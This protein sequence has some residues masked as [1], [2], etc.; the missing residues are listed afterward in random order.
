[1][2]RPVIIVGL[3]FGTTYS[4]IAWALQSS[5]EEDIEV[6]SSWPGG[7]NREPS[8]TR[9]LPTRMTQAGTS[10]K[11]PSVISYE[12]EKIQWGYQI[13][14][15][16]PA[17]RGLKLLLDEGQEPQYLP[18][19]DTVS[20]LFQTYGKTVQEATADYLR[21]LIH[22][23][24]QVLQRRLGLEPGQMDLQYTLTVPAVWSDKAK[25]VTL[26]AAVEAGVSHQSISLVTEPEAAALYVL[27]AIQPNTIAKNDVLVVCDAGGGTV[28]LISYQIKNLEPLSLAEVTEGTGAVCG[29]VLLDRRFEQLLREKMG[30]KAYDSLSRKSRE[31][32]VTYWQDKVKPNFTGKYD[33]DFSD[34]EYFIPVAGAVDDP[35][36]PIEDGFFLL[37]SEDTETI[38]DPIVDEVEELV[39]QQISGVNVAGLSTQAIILVGGFGASAYLFHRLSQAHPG[40]KVLQP[41]NGW[42]AV[43]SG[44]VQRGLAGNEVESRIARRN[45]GVA[46]QREYSLTE[47]GED[48]VGKQWDE[49]TEKYYVIGQMKWYIGRGSKITENEPIRMHF[50]RTVRVGDADGLV[51][52]RPLQ[53]SND[54]HP[55]Q[56]MD[57]R[58]MRLCE[59]ESD[60]RKIPTQLFHKRTNSKGVEYYHIPF[61]LS[62]TPTSASLV[63]ELEFNGVSYGSV[64]ARY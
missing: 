28:D 6:L 22:Q 41:P 35:A 48:C 14:P 27:S 34:V 50:F 61:V 45:Y 51:F 39:A 46:C 32:T 18:S 30:G 59:L 23:A 31:A 38:F 56:V 10:A 43:V 63:F 17:C 64:R 52:R 20:L 21:Q 19:M 24:L 13:G 8:T 44:A 60:L 26:C 29:S 40:V 49:L 5:S 54:E 4:G 33:E 11:V 57:K 1:M 15:L 36:V 53:F 3:D 37:T 42:S 55:P 16:A 58:V 9:Q 25:H 12:G 62:M 7:G 47:D 2:S